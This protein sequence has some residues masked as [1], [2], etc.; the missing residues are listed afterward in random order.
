MNAVYV[1]GQPVQLGA[2]LGKGG[3]GEVFRLADDPTKAVKLYTVADLSSRRAKVLAMIAKG[4]ADKTPQVAY[5]LAIATNSSGAFQGFVMRVV[6]DHQPFHELY[7]PGPRKA[8]F[9]SADYR[10]LVRAGL[11]IARAVASIHQTS[12]VI[13]DINH[14]SILISQKALVALIDAD[15]FQIV[16]GANKFLCRVGVPEYTPPELQGISLDSITRT[17]NHDAFGLAVVLFLLLFMGRHPFMGRPKRGDPPSLDEAI[18]AYR[19][20]YTEQRDVGLMLPPGTPLP[21]TI[22][23]RLAGLFERAFSNAGPV[24]RPTA[25]QW[26]EELSEF[27]KGLVQCSR[28]TL[29][30]VPSVATSCPWCQMEKTLGVILFVP[31]HPLP[32]LVTKAFDP[33]SSGFDLEK[34]WREICEIRC[35]RPDKLTPLLIASSVSSPSPAALDAAANQSSAE[36]PIAWRYLRLPLLLGATV[37]A[38]LWPSATFILSLIV[39]VYAFFQMKKAPTP[40]EVEQFNRRFVEAELKWRREL[41]RWVDRVGAGSFFNL[42]DD[43]RNKKQEYDQL[44]ATETKAVN[45]YKANLHHH[46][47]HVFLSSRLIR[48]AKLKGI[49]PAK[50]AALTLAG[51]ESAADIV[52]HRLTGV[53]GFGPVLRQ[54]LFDWRQQ[55]ERK[56]AFNAQLTDLDRGELAKIRLATEKRAAELRQGLLTGRENLKRLAERVQKVTS[57]PDPVLTAIHTERDQ[58]GYDLRHLGFTLPVVAVQSPQVRASSLGSPSP[59]SHSPIMPGASIGGNPQCPRCGR[60]M[61]KRIA[62]RGSNRG[63]AF[64]GCSRFPLCRATRPY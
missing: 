43:L 40:F 63:G 61:I 53:S 37:S 11:N 46:H 32:D 6:A 14:S 52:E 47:L 31:F 60:V 27:E 38:V 7:P 41:D 1:A 45:S 36:S 49:G 29:H 15:S 19:Y 58:A 23:S 12:C 10:F 4:L 55:N 16:E 18:K 28:N 2:R 20:A 35:P 56:F 26:V 64:W 30:Y 34:L 13:G 17:P 39:G 48:H 51:I 59:A 44:A 5:P 42:L 8:N 25:Q 62:R 57:S 24:Q 22:S 3:E 33:G 50:E 21:S 9:P 54:V